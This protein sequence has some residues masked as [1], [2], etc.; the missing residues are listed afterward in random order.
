MLFICAQSEYLYTL[1][2]IN[3][4]L[5]TVLITLRSFVI[6]RIEK[7]NEFKKQLKVYKENL[8]NVTI[9]KKRKR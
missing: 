8:C 6:N 5:F 3:L 1:K 4:L 2:S 7:I 9:K